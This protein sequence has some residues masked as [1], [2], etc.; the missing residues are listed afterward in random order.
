MSP[1]QRVGGIM[2]LKVPAHLATTEI[3]I[4]V[5]GTPNKQGEYEP[6]ST[7]YG[8]CRVE[9]RSEKKYEKEGR[10][11]KELLTAFVLQN[12]ESIPKGATGHV[13]FG[14]DPTQFKIDTCEHLLNPDG[15]V[16]YVKLEVSK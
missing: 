16:C 14:G 7:I 11:K 4:Q 12:F 5:H 8:R 6:V 10:K 13:T 15:S 2:R 9:P 1:V 3:V